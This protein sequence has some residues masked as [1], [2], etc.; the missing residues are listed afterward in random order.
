MNFTTFMRSSLM[1]LCLLA[2]SASGYNQY[3]KPSHFRLFCSAFPKALAYTTETKHSELL[4]APAHIQGKHVSLHKLTQND[5]SEYYEILNDERCT[6]VFFSTIEGLDPWYYMHYQLL[7][8]FFGERVVYSVMVNATG[9]L[10]GMIEL[11][12]DSLK[13]RGHIA[14]FASP[15]HWGSGIS[16]ETVNIVK[17]IFF[18][19]TTHNELHWH[20]DAKNHRCQT[21]TLKCGL[22]FSHVSQEPE[23]KNDLVFIFPRPQK[24]LN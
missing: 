11:I 6:T 3:T 14:G 8:Q 17:D 5:F 4:S 24:H 16:L 13:T 18:T 22:E 20:V 9:K 19:I 1:A 10:A 21:F 15:K 12:R 2:L 23:S 7:S